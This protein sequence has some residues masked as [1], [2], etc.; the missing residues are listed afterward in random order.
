M[1][2]VLRQQDYTNPHLPS[3]TEYTFPATI[4]EDRMGCV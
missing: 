3:L 4:T 2:S 1:I